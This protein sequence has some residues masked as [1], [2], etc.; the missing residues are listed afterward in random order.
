MVSGKLVGP[1]SGERAEA[2]LIC[3]LVY[4]LISHLSHP[5]N[6]NH[7]LYELSNYLHTKNKKSEMRSCRNPS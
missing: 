7:F 1:S 5:V 2:Q 4:Y 6:Q 3:P